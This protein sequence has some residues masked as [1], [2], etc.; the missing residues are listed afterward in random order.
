MAEEFVT[1]RE[2]DGFSASMRGEIRQVSESTMSLHGKLDTLLL[3]TGEEARAMGAMESTVKGLTDRMGKLED[4]V[5]DLSEAISNR[6]VQKVDRRL[7]WFG[8]L[9]LVAF[10]ALA[11]GYFSRMFK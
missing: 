11:G 7:G 10:A 8:Q 4:Q 9:I 6:E 5:R 2:F 1:V 3:K